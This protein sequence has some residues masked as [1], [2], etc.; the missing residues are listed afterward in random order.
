MNADGS[1]QTRLTTQQGT[2]N[3]PQWS[4][5]GQWILF[6]STRDG[7][8]NLWK[9]SAVYPAN[10]VQLT[11][12]PAH[13][14]S[15]G[16][17]WGKWSSD[18]SMI[19][20]LKGSP[21]YGLYVMNADGSD[22]TWLIP[23]LFSLHCDWSPTMEFEILTNRWHSKLAFTWQSHT[24]VAD[25]SWANPGGAATVAL[26]TPYRLTTAFDADDRASFSPDGQYVAVFAGGN[27]YKV[28]AGG[29]TPELL[30]AGSK[31]TAVGH[32]AWKSHP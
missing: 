24:W 11:G 31:K 1:G 26:G 18:G 25:I 9:M 17:A 14:E 5:D 6:N 2:D 13:P 16:G 29:G 30:V 23:N 22:P 19:A 20:F 21:N 3:G 4:P 28:P 27:I 32:P 15:N 7:S 8:L 10:V 12:T